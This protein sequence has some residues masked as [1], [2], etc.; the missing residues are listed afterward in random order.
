MPFAGVQGH[1]G[2]V[3]GGVDLGVAEGRLV[4]LKA[5]LG[6]VDLCLQ[7]F[8]LGAGGGQGGLGG[9]PGVITGGVGLAQP[10]LAVELHLRQFQL[11]ALLLQL[12][13]QGVQLRQA[14]LH[15]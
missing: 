6:L 10:L 14:R 12:R 2:A 13:A 5:G 9:L 3:A 1:H 15:L 4:A 8:D 11:G 7:H